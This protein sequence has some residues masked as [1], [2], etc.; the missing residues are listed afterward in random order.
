M[1]SNEQKTFSIDEKEKERTIRIFSDPIKLLLIYKIRINPGISSRQ[2]KEELTLDGTKIYYYLC[3]L[4]GIHPKTKQQINRP[5]V[6]IEK[7]ETSNHLIMK[8]YYPN[9]YMVEL[10]D[11]NAMFNI[12]DNPRENAKWNYT[13]KINLGIAFLYNH[14]REVEKRSLEDFEQE[15]PFINNIS[16]NKVI[17]MN[18]SLYETKKEIL[19]ENFDSLDPQNQ[20][21]NL[22]QFIKDASNMLINLGIN[23][24]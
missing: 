18:K 14:L 8:R 23:E 1:N 21:K 12:Y 4:E 17:F 16:D 13:L 2:L 7:E 6:R 24:K 15:S 20:K 19:K 3:E 22:F 10:G 11:H 9:D 5:L